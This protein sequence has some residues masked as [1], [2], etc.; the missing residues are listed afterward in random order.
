MMKPLLSERASLSI[1]VGSLALTVLLAA[2][3]LIRAGAG[4]QIEIAALSS[5]VRTVPRR[6]PAGL[7]ELEQP[8]WQQ[9]FF[10]FDRN[11][12]RTAMQIGRLPRAVYM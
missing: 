4:T 10:D 11:A 2:S 7:R 6:I 5:P 8:Q 1:I 12:T 9:R 3:G